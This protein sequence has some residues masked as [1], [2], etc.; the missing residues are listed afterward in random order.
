MFTWCAICTRYPHIYKPGGAVPWRRYIDTQQQPY[1]NIIYTVGQMFR[2][3]LAIFEGTRLFSIAKL[4]MQS[5]AR[6]RDLQTISLMCE[7]RFAK[8]YDEES[9]MF[10]SQESARR[11][12]KV[13]STIVLEGK[14]EDSAE[15][16]RP[17]RIGIYTPLSPDRSFERQPPATPQSRQEINIPWPRQIRQSFLDPFHVDMEKQKGNLTKALL[18]NVNNSLHYQER[19]YLELDTHLAPV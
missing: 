17:P 19:T 9:F 1:W 2:C 10:I 11:I 8:L 13:I 14:D 12:R 3:T 4:R 7:P 15:K 18:P 16:L 5:M 6:I